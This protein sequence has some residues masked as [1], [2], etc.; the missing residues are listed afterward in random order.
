MLGCSSSIILDSRECLDKH[1]KL[2]SKRVAKVELYSGAKT[3]ARHLYAT[4]DSL[5][6]LD[7]HLGREQAAPADSIFSIEYRSH[8]S[9]FWKGFI[10]VGLPL[11]ALQ[12]ATGESSTEAGLGMLAG[13]MVG[14]VSGFIGGIA[15]DRK[16][17]YYSKDSMLVRKKRL[18]AQNWQAFD[19]SKEEPG[20]K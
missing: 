18:H 13:G 15:G 3:K 12:G 14:A 17:Y 8:F 9:G 7:L 6:Y 2:G 16:H 20:L 19:A 1:N 11:V 5:F 10:G 4:P